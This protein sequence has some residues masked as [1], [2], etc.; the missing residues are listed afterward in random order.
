VTWLL[1]AAEGWSEPSGDELAASL[2]G[3]GGLVVAAMVAQGVVL[4]LG[5]VVL[6]RYVRRAVAVA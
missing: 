5:V 6:I 3:A 2:A 1:A 4:A